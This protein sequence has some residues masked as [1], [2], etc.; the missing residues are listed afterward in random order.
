MPKMKPYYEDLL[1]YRKVPG[2]FTFL[3][4]FR[5]HPGYRFITLLRL[6][7]HYSGKSFPGFIFHYWYNRMKWKYG[8]QIPVNTKIGKGLRI[9]HYGGIVITEQAEIGDYCHIGQGVT[10][11]QLVRGKKQGSPKI[12]NRVWISA[13]SV[14]VGNITIGNNVMIG[15]LSFIDFDIP[16]NAV[17][18]AAPPKIISY[19]GADEYIRFNTNLEK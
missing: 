8:L 3:R 9:A 5:S 11:G 15:P 1:I 12:G 13:N 17:I 19:N 4:T 10:I 6:C 14:I 7:R 2:F 18:A 16:D